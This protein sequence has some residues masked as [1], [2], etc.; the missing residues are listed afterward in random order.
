MS[1]ARE[2]IG[3]TRWT[4]KVG[5][6]APFITNVTGGNVSIDWVSGTDPSSKVVESVESDST[7]LTVFVEVDGGPFGWQP[8]VTVNGEAVT[9]SRIGTQAR[10]FSGSVAIAMAASG[11]ITVLCADGG[12]YVAPFTL[13]VGPAITGAVF[14]THP[15]NTGG[16]PL[17]PDAQTQVSD[18][19]T[20][21]ITG[22]MDSGAT[23]VYVKNAGASSTLQNFSVSGTSFDILVN[24]GSRSG[25]QSCTLYAKDGSGA[26]GDDFT[27]VANTVTL[28]QTYPTFG[29]DSIVYPANQLALKASE[30]CNVTLACTNYDATDTV[31][32]THNGTGEVSIPSSTTYATTKN[33]VQRTG[34]TYRDTGNNY[35]LLVTRTERNGRAA[36][37]YAS[38]WIANVAPPLTVAITGSPARLRSK[39]G[40]DKTYTV[41]LS[42]SHYLIDY[43]SIPAMARDAAGGDDG[44]ALPSLS[45]SSPDKTWTATMTIEEDDAKNTGA[46]SYSWLSV[47]AYGPAGLQATTITTNPTYTVG[48]FEERDI[49]FAGDPSYPREIAIG[50]QVSDKDNP[51]K[52]VAYDHLSQLLTYV[53]GTD[54]N[55]VSTPVSLSFTITDGAGNYDHD[56]TYYYWLDDDALY[57]ATAGATHT[58]EE[59]A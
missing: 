48:G 13:L 25:A 44:P 30:T 59:Q 2:H 39:T 33:G 43:P 4:G 38:I 55:P 18:D 31:S 20:V 58:L 47:S 14:D 52:L 32:Y 37:G 49:N 19:D 56:G 16:D 46:S 57:S 24:V 40:A 26:Q 11:D 29:S 22:T 15:D 54:G 3:D 35:R 9:L 53:A 17:C 7:S 45:G 23:T 42:S 28:D 6:A 5:V 34:G 1:E 12:G 10:R 41:T 8:T 51:N 50:T 36:S 27:I 21:R